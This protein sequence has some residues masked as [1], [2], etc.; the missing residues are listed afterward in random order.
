VHNVVLELIMNNVGRAVQELDAARAIA[1]VVVDIQV[2][3]GVIGPPD[4]DSNS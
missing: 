1:D 4:L 2:L 3:L